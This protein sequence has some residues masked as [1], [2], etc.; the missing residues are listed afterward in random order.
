MA[1]DASNRNGPDPVRR[2]QALH[3]GLESLLSPAQVDAALR[4]WDSQFATS[5]PMALAEYVAELS[6]LLQ[7]GSVQER[8][9]LRVALYSALARHEVHKQATAAPAAA[10]VR[11]PLP[12]ANA[13]VVQAAAPPP[14]SPAFIVFERMASEMLAAVARSGAG[15]VRDF[16][17]ALE[18]HAASLRLAPETFGALAAWIQRRGDLRSL[19]AFGEDRFSGLMHA[20]YAAAAEALGPVVADRALARAAQ[21][22]EALPEARQFSPGRLM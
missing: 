19:A 6:Q 3:L 4:I 2:R 9:A 12:A 20:I 11:A 15:E 14:A 21:S 16:A 8:H 1:S 13:P 7:L 22:A 5:R 18:R 17:A 10:A